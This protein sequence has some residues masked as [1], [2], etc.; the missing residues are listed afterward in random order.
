M[1]AVLHHFSLP[2]QGKD[3]SSG[4][5]ILLKK[6]RLMGKMWDYPTNTCFAS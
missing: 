2:N 4:K 6:R 5:W 3:G 1:Q